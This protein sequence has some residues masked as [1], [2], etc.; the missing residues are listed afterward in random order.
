MI[1]IANKNNSSMHQVL[2]TLVCSKLT[3]NPTN[4]YLFKVK[5]RSTRKRCEI[6]SKLT[7]KTPEWRQCD[8]LWTYFTLFSSVFIIEF[9]KVNVS[10]KDARIKN[11]F[12]FSG[13]FILK[14]INCFGKK[15][16][17]RRFIGFIMYLCTFRVL[18][19]F[20]NLKCVIS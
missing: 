13:V 7:T 20:G 1:K 5:N 11:L 18:V 2:F 3:I 14:A 15:F 17:L 19:F 4:V 16:H 8:V 9:A 6:C 10:W 12:C